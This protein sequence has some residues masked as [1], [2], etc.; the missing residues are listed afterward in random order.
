MSLPTVSQITARAIAARG[1]LARIKAV[2]TQRLIGTISF[3]DSVRHPFM[4]EMKRPGMMRQEITMNGATVVST[5][6]AGSGW[7][8][9]PLSGTAGAQ[10]LTAAQVKNIAAGADVDGPLVDSQAKGYR[11]ELAGFEAVEG[12]DAY[13]LKV[14]GKDGDVRYA[15][16]D[17]QSALEVK[18]EGQVHQEGGTVGFES[19]FRNHRKVDGVMYAFEIDSQAPGGTHQQ[20]IVFDRVL[21]NPAIDDAAFGKPVAARK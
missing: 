18:W 8:L 11:I 3:G 7:M 2:R 10:P 19:L 12:R 14:T 1:G 15:Y 16:I 20:K 6:R 9:N 21:V 4:V 5:L 13:K 17:V